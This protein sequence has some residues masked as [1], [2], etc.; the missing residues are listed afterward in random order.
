MNKPNSPKLS[1]KLTH[2]LSKDT[3]VI[4]FDSFGNASHITCHNVQPQYNKHSNHIL[5]QFSTTYFESAKKNIINFFPQFP[6]IEFVPG[7]GTQANKRAIL[8]SISKKPKFISQ[9][10]KRNIILVGSIEH[11]SILDYIVPSLV[12]NDYIVISIPCDIGGIISYT[13]L[14]KLLEKHNETICMVSI[15][16]VNNETGIIQPIDK[17]A[18]L[19]HTKKY[20][21]D[22]IFHSDITQGFCQF[23]Q[24]HTEIN[25]SHK[26]PDIVTFSGYKL[27]GPYQGVVLSKYKLADDYFGTVDIQSICRLSLIICDTLRDFMNVNIKY[28]QIKKYMIEQL[29]NIFSKLNVE[30]KFLTNIDNSVNNAVSLLLFGYQSTVIQHMLS[31]DN[32]CIG[33]GSACQNN[34]N[35]NKNGYGS[36]VIKQ[37][38]YHNDVTYN[39]IRITWN[40]NVYVNIGDNIHNRC[41]EDQEN[42]YE[43]VDIF[44]EHL[45]KI[46]EK[47]KPIVLVPTQILRVSDV[48][49]FPLKLSHQNIQNRPE[50]NNLKEIK[51]VINVSDEFT[52]QPNKTDSSDVVMHKLKISIG[53]TYLKG[54]NRETFINH[55]ICDIKNRINNIKIKNEKTFLIMTYPDGHADDLNNCIPILT[56]I[57]GISLIVPLQCFKF[58]KS[59]SEDQLYEKIYKLLEQNYQNG[60]SICIRTSVDKKSFDNNSSHF[61]KVLGTM[62]VTRSTSPVNLKNPDIEYCINILSNLVEI[63]TKKYKGVD[64]LPLKSIGL[65]EIIMTPDNVLRSIV[66]AIQMSIRGVNIICNMINVDEESINMFKKI[67]EKI[68][69]Y[70]QYI[71]SNS[72]SNIGDIFSTLSND[73]VLYELN[74]AN[75][76]VHLSELK[77]YGLIYRKYITAITC[78]MSFDDIKKF[79]FKFDRV[80]VDKIICD[81]II[82]MTNK[83]DNINGYLSMISGGIDSPISTNIMNKLIK[84][85]QNNQNNQNNQIGQIS[86]VG[87]VGHVGQVDQVGQVGQVG[88][89]NQMK[90][91]HFTALIDKIN[92]VKELRDKIDMSLELFVVEFGDLQHEITKVCPENYRTILFKIF[93]VKIA[94][95][96]A[97]QNNLSGIIMGNSIGQVASQTYQNLVITDKFSD[98]PIY[99]PLLGISKCD[100]I[101]EARLINTYEDSICT[102]T[103]DC[104]VMYLPKHPVLNAK[105]GVAKKFVDMFDNF[106]DYVVI[107]KI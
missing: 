92:V 35:N 14:E 103:N 57:P 21:S 46:I 72:N 91:V 99:N 26:I 31:N 70:V 74:H 44:V 83:N 49:K 69:P 1:P 77:Q 84:Q 67:V 75:N 22:I 2:L 100:I 94:N 85:N 93:M 16:S 12:S 41:Q 15:M 81:D 33:I 60:K 38:G 50:K 66:A 39:L 30:Y 47:L 78:H 43:Y 98:L 105:Y 32:I 89:I 34:I 73:L 56:K 76:L 25:D 80:E 45:Y 82:V 54:E 3:G 79:I 37:M 88:Q 24:L 96:I 40:N 71:I 19:I 28:L 59:L 13:E 90:L 8:G 87:Q 23:W 4:N 104:C 97:K 42:Y 65:A 29:Q 27:G 7:G 64:G 6:V 51:Y 17:Y 18:E 36:Y 63:S 61:N 53:E 52:V 107:H 101:D 10:K 106:M 20:G 48:N 95:K 68:N 9:G 55:L 11:K 62:M 86:Q 5:G 102:G 58:N